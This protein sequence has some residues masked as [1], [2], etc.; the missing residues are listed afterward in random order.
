M[1]QVLRLGVHTGGVQITGSVSL[2][3]AEFACV[4]LRTVFP[5]V[6]LASCPALHTVTIH[7][8]S[9]CAPEDVP[10]EVGGAEAP[11]V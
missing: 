8:L 6:D 7:E 1:H 9:Y 5:H 3:H 2:Q 11:C 4:H 10:D